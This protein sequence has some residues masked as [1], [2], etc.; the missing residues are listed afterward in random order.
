MKLGYSWN[1]ICGITL[2]LSIAKWMGFIQAD[3]LV[4][5]IFVWIPL[6]IAMLY[7]IGT[8]LLVLTILVYS[9][10]GG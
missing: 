4:I 1:Q 9:R 3:W 6:F 7:I 2:I 10:L 5:T 8:G